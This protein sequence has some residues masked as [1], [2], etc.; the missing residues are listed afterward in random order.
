MSLKLSHRLY[1]FSQNKRSRTLT[2]YELRA[3]ALL[4][5][6]HYITKAGGGRKIKL[7][8][9]LIPELDGVS[10]QVQVPASAGEQ[11]SLLTEY[12]SERPRVSLD[13]VSNR[14]LQFLG[15]LETR[16]PNL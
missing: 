3:A 6:K 5:L 14:K 16:P 2:T 13:V 8:E 4:C 9:F 11:I 1:Q 7:C 15:E 12:C 10:G